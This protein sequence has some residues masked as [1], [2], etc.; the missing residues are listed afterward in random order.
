MFNLKIIKHYNVLLLLFVIFVTGCVTDYY[1]EVDQVK[2]KEYFPKPKNIDPCTEEIRFQ[3]KMKWSNY[4]Y[5]P[6][7]SIFFPDNSS[8][9]WFN[10]EFLREP[11]I[12]F[13]YFSKT[14]GEENY[15]VSTIQFHP[16][17]NNIVNV[18]IE[19]IYDGSKLKSKGI[20][21][22]SNNGIQQFT[23]D[24]I[25]TYD[26]SSIYFVFDYPMTG[27]KRFFTKKTNWFPKE[28]IEQITIT[29]EVDG[30]IEKKIFQF[31]LKWMYVSYWIT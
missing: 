1:F 29:Y 28:M 4:P 14:I 11:N 10:I 20:Y 7:G 18:T 26:N 13:E 24:L 12:S 15:L 9:I 8:G 17:L 16:G 3:N 31:D 21:N 25:N 2:Y 5:V 22:V 27:F 30:K 6:A 23:P 19:S